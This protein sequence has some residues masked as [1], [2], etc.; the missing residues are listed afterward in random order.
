MVIL[1]I[2]MTL[3]LVSKLMNYMPKKLLFHTFIAI[4]LSFNKF[5][6]TGLYI[7]LAFTDLYGF[8]CIPNTAK[9]FT[10][11]NL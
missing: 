6:V 5:L 10:E 3:L 7:V 1:F 2:K 4:L 8:M 11:I 9:T